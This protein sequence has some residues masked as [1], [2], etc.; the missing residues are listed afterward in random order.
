MMR[1][2]AK[3][4]RNDRSQSHVE[5]VCKDGTAKVVPEVLLKVISPEVIGFVLKS[6][7]EFKK[8]KLDVDGRLIPS[9]SVPVETDAVLDYAIYG[10]DYEK[11][12]KAFLFL[13]AQ[14]APDCHSLVTFGGLSGDEIAK[15]LLTCADHDVDRGWNAVQPVFGRPCY[16]TECC[17]YLIENGRDRPYLQ[18]L[19]FDVLSNG[20][21]SGHGLKTIVIYDFSS[22]EFTRCIADILDRPFSE[23]T[24]AERVGLRSLEA[25]P[26]FVHW[27]IKNR[28]PRLQNLRMERWLPNVAKTDPVI[29]LGWI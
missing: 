16:K 17:L 1:N 19:A 11:H 2:A 7:M 26:W 28:L 25:I 29:L 10:P 8:R 6:G 15:C 13:H 23:R 27:R 18:K 4:S 20:S 12:M 14:N 3:R 5:C 9:I 24:P 22:N 21:V